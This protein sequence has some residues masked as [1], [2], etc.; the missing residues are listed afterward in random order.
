MRMRAFSTGWYYITVFRPPTL[1]RFVKD[2]VIRLGPTVMVAPARA[3]PELLSLCLRQGDRRDW[4]ALIESLHPIIF[5]AAAR[6]AARWGEVRR[7]QVEDLTQDAF[8][9]LCKNDCRILRQ[10][11]NKP[12][13]AT[14]VF[15]KVTVSNLVHDHFRAERAGRRHPAGGLLSTDFADPWL[16]ETRSVDVVEREIFLKQIDEALRRRLSGPTAHRDHRIFWLY[17]RHGLTAKDIAS[18]PV[19]GLS[20]KGVESAIHRATVLVKEELCALKGKS[21]EGASN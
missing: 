10:V 14:V 13:G 8:L 16:G 2:S 7:D 9:K 21:Q 17:N 19:I 4:E 20:E 18:I 5:S 15:L 6:A 12:E 1:F 3:L 11:Q